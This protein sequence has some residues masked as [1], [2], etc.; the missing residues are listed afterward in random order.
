MRAGKRLCWARYL[1]T[2]ALCLLAMPLVGAERSE[3]WFSVHLDG[4][5]LGHMQIVR[6][7]DGGEVETRQLQQMRLER[8][9]QSMLI[10]SEQRMVETEEGVPL[11][12][13][14]RLRMG[15][16]ETLIDGRIEDAELHVEIT[17]GEQVSKQQS[18]WPEGAL[19][20]EGQRLVAIRAGAAAGAHFDYL[21]FDLDALQPVPVSVIVLGP[22][23]VKLL[24]RRETLLAMRHTLTLGNSSLTSDIWITPETHE[25]RRLR[26]PMLG[27]QLDAV[28]CD[29]VCAKAPDQPL[30]LLAATSVPAPRE[31]GLRER[32]RALRYAINLLGDRVPPMSAQLGQV[33]ENDGSAVLLTV[34]TR[35]SGAQPPSADDL[36]ANRWV[37]SDHAELMAMAA[38]FAGDSA[39]AAQ[40][41]ARL[42][43]G[44]ARHIRV[45]S[46]RIGYA[47]AL[48]AARLAE[49]DCTEH[50]LLLAALARARG[51]P[52][53]VAT[54]IAYVAAGN[55]KPAQFVPHAWVYAW[56]D[57]VWQGADAA[58]PEFGAGHI[59]FDVGNG[60]PFSFYAGLNLLGQLQISDI[61]RVR[62]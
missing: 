31:L 8:D 61:Q 4:R 52:A 54:G 48:E 28:A 42:R 51:I 40:V 53:R 59:A 25:L 44:V 6:S 7:V 57:G 9:G 17:Q 33:L 50:A 2:S 47:S 22:D 5:K 11:R 21:S 58:L 37:Q 19:L 16:A 18:A 23:E 60:D 14:N 39:D 15:A 56:I 24:D 20:A 29:E 35:G 38:T 36:R 13:H 27:V 43:D 1:L 62:R 32:R 41:M 55:G 3:Q 46:L 34:D 12:F 49:G 30:D 26:M 10:A 45:K